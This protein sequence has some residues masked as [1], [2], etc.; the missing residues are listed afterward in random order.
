MSLRI[1]NTAQ[2]L[3]E[4]R[5]RP[6]RAFQRKPVGLWWGFDQGW[7]ELVGQ[8]RTRAAQGRALG[9]HDYEVHLGAGFNML[10]LTSAEDVLEFSRRFGQPMPHA[11]DGFFWQRPGTR[12]RYD[13]DQ[14]PEMPR[15]ARAFLIDWPEVA[16]TWDGIEITCLGRDR[17]TRPEVEWLDIDWD[18]PS[19]CA[20]R[21]DHLEVTLMA[22]PGEEITP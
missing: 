5:D 8:G 16:R 6:S 1:H 20:W 13:P 9:A 14:D 11:A 21:T 15:R 10:S 19:G 17:G 4:F 7:H 22:A 12:D 3:D 2:P 18:I